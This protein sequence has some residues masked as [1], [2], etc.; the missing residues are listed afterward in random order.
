MMEKRADAMR[1]RA[2]GV[3]QVGQIVV[4]GYSQSY[5]QHVHVSDRGCAD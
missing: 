4:D 5:R 1:A 2:Q 3:A